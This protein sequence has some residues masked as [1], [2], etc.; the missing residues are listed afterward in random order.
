M[1]PTPAKNRARKSKVIGKGITGRYDEL[2]KKENA[3][4]RMQGGERRQNIETK[5]IDDDRSSKCRG[6][7][8]EP[9]KSTTGQYKKQL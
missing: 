3:R 2:N 5:G 4:R 7:T 6:G 1:Q 8:N 9:I